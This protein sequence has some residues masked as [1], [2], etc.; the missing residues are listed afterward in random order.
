MLP[1]SDFKAP[2]RSGLLEL[3][4]QLGQAWADRMAGLA[5]I[6]VRALGV[7]TRQQQLLQA[8]RPNLEQA[9]QLAR[10][11]RACRAMGGEFIFH[12]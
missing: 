1:R 7:E 10:E 11:A 8:L 2:T 5:Q 4:R 12:I 6:R 9:R 3:E